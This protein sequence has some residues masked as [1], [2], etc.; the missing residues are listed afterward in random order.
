M[1]LVAVTRV[2]NQADII[3]AFVRHHAGFVDH[4]LILDIG[5]VDGTVEILKALR[6][7]GHRISVMQTRSLSYAALEQN[8]GLLGL[9]VRQHEADWVLFLSA[10]DFIDR[11]AAT[12]TLRARLD[13]LEP[14]I[15][16]LKL[17]LVTYVDSAADQ[18][19]EAVV[20]RRI[21]H[22]TTAAPDHHRVFV[23]TKRLADGIVVGPG[24]H[25]VQ[26]GGAEPPFVMAS[27]WTLAHYP[28]RSAWQE[29][30]HLTI[31]RLQ[32]L[33]AGPAWARSNLHDEFKQPFEML[34]R[35][36]EA[37]L[38]DPART[39]PGDLGRDDLMVDPI[40]YAGGE[41]RYTRTGEDP[42]MVA[43]RCVIDFAA[44][45]AA[46]HGRLVEENAAIRQQVMQW[47]AQP[48]TG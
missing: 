12:Q 42:R 45:L 26:I 31:G 15:V 17:P 8:T 3:E 40:D 19:S 25:S 46:Q 7:D 47:S 39:G 21:T 30:S 23:S 33:A 38:A 14:E 24:Q 37:V 16:A 41:L 35:Q 34:R 44:N 9:A 6:D 29:L 13:A 5:S 20:P 10:E 22:R 18:A 4:H 28:R 2:L 36:P 27:D 1:K 48:V 11:R 43:V 32:L